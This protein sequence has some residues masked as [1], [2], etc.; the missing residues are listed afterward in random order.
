[1]FKKILIANRGEIAL[2]VMRACR[3]MGIPSVAIYSDADRGGLHVRSADEAH[4]VGPAPSAES[5]L[6][7]PAILDIA[8]KTGCEAIHPGYGFVSE[9]A[10]FASACAEAGITFI[11][12]PAS[13]IEAMGDKV[14]ARNR[15][16]AAGVPV[17]PGTDPLPH[18]PEAALAAVAKIGYPI[19]LKASAG[20]GGKGMRVIKDPAD[21]PDAL[22]AARSLARS[23]FGDEQV[24]A[25][26]YLEEPHHIE[27]QLLAD[28]QGNA[29]YLFERECSVQRRHQKVVEETPSTFVSRDIVRQ[30]GEIAVKAAKAVGYT[31]A[32][33]VEFLVDRHKHFYFLEMNTRLQVEHPVTEMTTGIDLVKAQ[34]RVANGEAL[35]FTQQ[36]LAQ[37][38][39]AIEVRVY[40][41][42]PEENYLPSPGKI[43]AMRLPCGPGIR[44]DE[45]FE[46]G[47]EVPIY[48][49]PMIAKLIVH[50]D[51]RAT[52]IARMARAL[53]EYEVKGIRTNLA[54]L[55]SVILH[56]GFG[57]GGYDTGFLDQYAS[58]IL[59]PLVP[60]QDDKARALVVAAVR[61]FEKSK[62]ASPAAGSSQ[63]GTAAPASRWKWADRVK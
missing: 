53:A 9:R 2:R 25:E 20:G 63:N 23:A 21:L 42:D 55:H 24:Y 60:S 52:A 61:A 13:A 44:L 30:M 29:V 47:D 35:W 16:I 12:P 58:E 57:R 49:D 1:M 37:H 31:G 46:A 15:M 32:G 43:T 18:D 19:M 14:H 11:G 45:G 3:E 33:T 8:K 51:D 54:F 48:Y 34:I 5:Y 36:D 4:R 17:V 6:N 59:A 56:P 26:R 7:I 41:E 40:A 62:Q 39:H 28:T 38:G 50:A 27:I 22:T 10:A